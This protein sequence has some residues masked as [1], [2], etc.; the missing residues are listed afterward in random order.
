MPDPQ[1]HAILCAGGIGGLM[2]ACLAHAG[3][4]VTMVVRRESV[5]QYPRE[6]RLESPFGNIAAAVDCA[7]EVP[8]A[9]VVWVTVK[10]TQLNEAL[11]AITTPAAIKSIVPLLNGVD[12]LTLLRW[13]YGAESVIPATI[14]VES[15]RVTPGRIVH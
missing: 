2:G 7:A 12:H 6:I 13:K 11:K 3:A 8:P 15:E 5:A 1:R 14:A 10:A 9:D 4:R